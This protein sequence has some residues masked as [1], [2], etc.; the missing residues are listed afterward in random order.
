MRSGRAAHTVA[1]VTVRRAAG[2]AVLLVAVM[3]AAAPA[4]A[5]AAALYSQRLVV[6]LADGTSM[7]R[8]ERAIEHEGGSV[9]RRLGAIRGVVVRPRAGVESKALLSRLRK[10]P[11]V[12]YAEPDFLIATSAV[13]DDP[14]FG[15]QYALDQISGRDVSA[16]TAWDEATACSKIAVLDS[17]VDKNHPD[18]RPNLWVNSGEKSGNGKDD[19][20][21]GFVDDYY[22]A[23]ATDHK[24]SGLDAN[25][26]GT[27]VAGIV[28]ADGNNAT[29]VSGVCWTAPIMSVRFLDERGRGGSADAADAIE[30]AVHEGAKVINCSFGSSSKSSALQS[31][32]A[33]AKSAGAL[34][35]VAAGNDGDNIDAK[36]S[37]PASYADGNILTVA[38]STRQDTLA[39][40][41]NY[42]A[43]AVD[44]AAP[45]DG[46]LSTLEGGGY[47]DKDGTSM[48]A[49][50]VA[51]A[52]ALLRKAKP[53][54]TYSEIRTALRQHGDPVSG[55][56]GKVL[57]GQRLNVRRA[58]DQLR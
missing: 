13:P 47:G 7:A 1:V 58:L 8:G 31:A 17:G 29:G 53:D 10:S 20:H 12:R 6:A 41:S 36:P 35:V 5:D 54:A 14:M 19:D 43:K 45:G 32:I 57:Y 33:H 26:H 34:L 24:G 56:T 52:A 9:S 38:A 27:H 37:Y 39:G 44:V 11:L 3:A 15:D 25:G 49:P 46:I 2:P 18:L 48:A 16:T 23:D 42:G 22:G 4:H 40:F 50:L 28:G 51:G 21:N 30:Y 55:L